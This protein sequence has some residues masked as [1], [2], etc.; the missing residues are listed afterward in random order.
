MFLCENAFSHA[1][2]NH[3]LVAICFL[4]HSEIALILADQAVKRHC[5]LDKCVQRLYFICA[6]LRLCNINAAALTMFTRSTAAPESD[7]VEFT[8]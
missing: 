8:A 2:Q 4:V 7:K 3:A 6:K 1:V 5:W